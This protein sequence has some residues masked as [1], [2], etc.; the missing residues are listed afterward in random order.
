MRSW[1]WTEI[2]QTQGDRSP[3]G[4]WLSDGNRLLDANRFP[5]GNRLLNGSRLAMESSRWM[6]QDPVLVTAY[7]ILALEAAYKN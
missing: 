7:A 6:E 1:I 2:R 5:N 4:I 3:D